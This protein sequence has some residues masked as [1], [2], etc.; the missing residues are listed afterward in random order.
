MNADQ[1]TNVALNKTTFAYEQIITWFS[2]AN[3]NYQL[4]MIAGAVALAFFIA[5]LLRRTI[6]AIKEPEGGIKKLSL[7]WF[8]RRSGRLIFPILTI[9]FLVGVEAVAVTLF[10]NADVIDAAQRLSIIFLMWVALS[11]YVESPLIRTAGIWILVPAA[12]LHTF[13]WFEPAVNYLDS[14]GFTLGEVEITAYTIVK[15]IFYVCI[16]LWIGRGV[17]NLSESYIRGVSSIGRSTQELL[18]KMVDIFLYVT[19]FV[20]TL[21]LVGID[22][23]VLAVFGGA[24]G[25]GIGFGLQKIASNFISG[26]ILLTERS[27]QINNLVEMDDGVLGYVRKLGA[28]ASVLETFDGKEVLVPNEDFITSRV[29]NLTQSSNK[30]RIDVNVGVSYDTDIHHAMELILKAANEYEAASQAKGEEP[31]VFLREYGDSSVNF[32]LTFWLEDVTTGRW[33]TQSDVMLTIW[34][35]FKEHDIEIPFPQQDIH[36]RSGLEAADKPKK[37]AA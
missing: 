22:L 18:V 34:D 26:I 36:I 9:L 12:I 19:L 11:A 31:K 30:G 33:R 25:V 7:K 15:A 2:S 21:N 24:I 20:I 1:I 28:R 16:I 4:A 10:D 35:S 37:K 5:L 23:T 32:T 13:G 8:V 27:I 17:S 14:Y 3:F 6:K 29:S